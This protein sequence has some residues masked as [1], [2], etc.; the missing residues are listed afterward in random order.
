[1]KLLTSLSTHYAS[2]C[3]TF[4][5]SS[6]CHINNTTIISPVCRLLT[7]MLLSPT[8]NVPPILM[9]RTII[10]SH[11]N[12]ILLGLKGFS[13][14]SRSKKDMIALL[15]DV[16]QRQEVHDC[17]F[18]TALLH[19]DVILDAVSTCLLDSK[20]HGLVDNT[21]TLLTEMSRRSL[22]VRPLQVQSAVELFSKVQ[23][24][25]RQ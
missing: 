16:L 14:S 4:L 25:L 9:V 6:L 18:L 2:L 19:A 22:V 15:I 23:G 8:S 21:A 1:M 24:K 11:I 13:I 10:G 12:D 7:A 3:D 5:L 17:V 20:E